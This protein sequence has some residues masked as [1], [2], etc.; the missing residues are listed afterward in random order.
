MVLS[1]SDLGEAVKDALDPKPEDLPDELKAYCKGIISALQSATVTLSTHSGVTAPG[2][3]LIA[4]TATGGIMV[5]Q[6][7][8]MLAE[9]ASIG[10]F[11]SAEA[12]ALTTYM[13]TG[14]ISFATGNINGV[15]TN[16]P[17]SPGPLTNGSAQKGKIN[18]LLGPAAASFVAGATGGQLA[19][20]L[21]I[22]IYSAIMDYI[23][24]EAEVVFPSGTILGTCPPG[25]GPLA[26][27]PSIGGKVS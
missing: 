13:S 16:T 17:T 20:P 1:V 24:A 12:T 25:G 4:G 21:S 27:L 10:P 23:T 22:P 18:G 11:A 6:P 5:V 14:L 15:C 19:G 8:P 26:P 2:S 9:T 7:G 3:P